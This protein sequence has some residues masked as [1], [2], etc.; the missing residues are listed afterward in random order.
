MLLRSL[1]LLAV[2]CLAIVHPAAK[3]LAAAPTSIALTMTRPADGAP[4][5]NLAENLLTLVELAVQ[6]EGG[7]T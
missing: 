6:A 1:I 4:Q 2:A 5:Q 3:V 7:L